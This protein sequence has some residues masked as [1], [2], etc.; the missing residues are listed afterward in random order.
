VNLYLDTSALVKLYLAEEGSP[1]VRG[2]VQTARLVATST[3]V[4]VEARAAFARR[5]REGGMSRQ[6]HRR[7]QRDLERDWEHYVRL[8]VSEPLVRSAARLA[9]RERLRAH[10]ALHLASAL[11]L[12]Q[13]LAA[14]V[15][16]ACWDARLETAARRARLSVLP[17]FQ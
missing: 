11:T 2:A 5:Q 9:E 12:K 16:F 8:Q 17:G 13:R 15:V 4:Y 10:D 14:P 7:I 1:V 6:D 3:L